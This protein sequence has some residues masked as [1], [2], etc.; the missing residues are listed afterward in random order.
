MKSIDYALR[1]IARG[2]AVLPV[3]N[4]D[5]LGTGE[6]ACGGKGSCKPGK[7]P[8]W[9]LVPHGVKDASTDEATVRE[10]FT[11]FPDANVAIA[12]GQISGGLVIFDID[13]RNGG[14]WSVLTAAFGP[15]L[16]HSMIVKTGGG[17]WHVYTQ[18]EGP[19]PGKGNIV[20]GIDIKGEGGYIIAPPSNHELG[21]VY[22]AQTAKGIEPC[23]T[24]HERL[25]ELTGD[26]GAVSG[27]STVSVPLD[28]SF[29]PH[30]AAVEREKALELFKASPRALKAYK[31]ELEDIDDKSASGQDMVLANMAAREGWDGQEIAK[32]IANA[33][34][35]NGDRPNGRSY[36]SSTAGAAIA[37]EEKGAV[38]HSSPKTVKRCP[39]SWSSACT[40]SLRS[41]YLIVRP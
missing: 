21:D 5:E 2:W 4:I 16:E 11:R 39:R 17:G 31:R 14:S 24:P 38:S 18:A 30:T 40:V 12:T 13:P 41:T 20:P 8:I 32:L 25:R 35:V 28:R 36:Y 3:W 26:S 9:E 10:W 7:H 19:V 1:Y 15:E 29:D 27:D 22:A 6:C 33:R 23:R 34:R 37:A